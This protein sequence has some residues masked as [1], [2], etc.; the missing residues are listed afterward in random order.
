MSVLDDIISGV[1]EDLAARQAQVS[2][3]DLRA[4][5]ADVDAPRDPMPQL[6]GA[7]S[8]VIS[9]V[10]R[11][12]PSKGHLADIPDPTADSTRDAD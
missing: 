11:K 9:E 1:R 5:L 6:R 7:G 4:A 3:A 2:V 8:S 10:K 12:S